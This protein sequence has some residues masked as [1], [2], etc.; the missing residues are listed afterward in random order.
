MGNANQIKKIMIINI[1]I[2][3]KMDVYYVQLDMNLEKI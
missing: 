2:L 1:A 3:L